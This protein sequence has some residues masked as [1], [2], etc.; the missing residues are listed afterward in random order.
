MHTFILDKS[1]GTRD[2]VRKLVK[3]ASDY[4]DLSAKECK[5]LVAAFDEEK[6]ATH[7]R[8][9]NLSVKTRNAECSNSFKAIIDEVEAL[10]QRIG[11]EAL[12]VLVHSTCDLNIEPKVHFTS[13]AVEQYLRTATRKH[14]MEFACKLEGYVI[15]G[16]VERSG[17]SLTHKEC[18]K[19]AKQTIR[20]GMQAGL[21]AIT[22]CSEANF[23]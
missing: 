10:K 22:G 6:E 11:T 23:E 13:S 8:P 2:N 14:V 15:S 12:V 17:L 9:P 19:K 5:Q 18:V 1:V 3:R 20:G 21:L 16:D 4:H 7:H